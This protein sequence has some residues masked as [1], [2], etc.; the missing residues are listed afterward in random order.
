MARFFLILLIIFGFASAYAQTIEW[1]TIDD[2]QS[3]GNQIIR[4]S[5]QEIIQ[6]RWYTDNSSFASYSQDGTVI[7]QYDL[8]D[9]LSN[10]CL[11]NSKILYAI[12]K[13]SILYLNRDG[14]IYLSNE[15]EGR[16]EFINQIVTDTILLNDRFRLGENP[17]QRD[18]EIWLLSTTF[19]DGIKTSIRT[20]INLETFEFTNSILSHPLRNIRYN[21]NNKLTTLIYDS[22]RDPINDKV[23]VLDSALNEILT[24]SP[25]IRSE[26][27]LNAIVTD[28]NHIITVG[29]R[30]RPNSTFGSCK[31]Y[32][33]QGDL[34]WE[35]QYRSEYDDF[36]FSFR[37]V[38][39]KNNTLIIGGSESGCLIADIHIISLDENSGDQLWKV[40]EVLSGGGN[41][42]SQIL[43]DD[44]DNLLVSGTTA[45]TDYGGPERAFI[46]KI[47]NNSTSVSD[48]DNQSQDISIYP[49]P[50]SHNLYIDGINP[51]DKIDIINSAGIV[52]Q[53][54]AGTKSL[55]ISQLESG[56]YFLKAY[57]QNKIITKKFVVE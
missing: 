2:I 8:C 50:V 1:T 23:V 27:I 18:N 46:M 17:F 6:S 53:R 33:L 28:N 5:H 57:T 35:F 26:V 43:I 39:Q 25:S 49:N 21:H 34:L 55:D 4:N 45:V 19:P 36:D 32:N 54:V 11:S 14:K 56:N 22:S 3:H 40:V 12:S 20:I 31:A 24:I 30:D 38:E 37:H 51:A 13:D 41:A 9:T 7:R 42:T 29:T 47:S 52:I 10:S 16:V 15:K 48:T 44:N